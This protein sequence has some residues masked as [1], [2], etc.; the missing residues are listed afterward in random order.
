MCERRECMHVQGVDEV[1]GDRQ[2][3]S[4][5]RR[6]SS[7]PYLHAVHTRMWV[8]PRHEHDDKRGA[9]TMQFGTGFDDLCRLRDGDKA[10]A[11][12][13]RGGGTAGWRRA[14]NNNDIHSECAVTTVLAARDSHRKRAQTEVPGHAAQRSRAAQANTNGHPAVGTRVAGCALRHECWG[15]A[16]PCRAGSEH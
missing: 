15:H 6:T 14:T 8:R 9:T 11:C 3:S 13:G 5:G 2:T 7:K 16:R 1:D 12:V 10:S 4:M